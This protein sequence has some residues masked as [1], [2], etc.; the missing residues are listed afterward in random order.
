VEVACAFASCFTGALWLEVC[1]WP[2]AVA[3]GAA[4]PPA[5]CWVLLCSVWF[6]FVAEPT[7]EE[8]LC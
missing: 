4:L 6:S 7:A 2:G 1:A 3:V 5:C 8:S